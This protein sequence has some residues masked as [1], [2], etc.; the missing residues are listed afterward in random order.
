MACRD[1]DSRLRKISENV[2]SYL[3]VKTLQGY[4]DSA[5]E[6]TYTGIRDI[7]NEAN[8]IKEG[9]SLEDYAY[10]YVKGMPR[11]FVRFLRVADK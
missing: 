1:E 7:Y 9:E 2:K 10:S 3:L 5:D 6:E 8:D 4:A 11:T